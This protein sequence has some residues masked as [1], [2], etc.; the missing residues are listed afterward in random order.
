MEAGN[1]K[2]VIFEI[3]K[4]KYIPP[5]F[6]LTVLKELYSND[7]TLMKIV[8]EKLGMVGYLYEKVKD[9]ENWKPLFLRAVKEVMWDEFLTSSEQ[10]K[11]VSAWRNTEDFETNRHLFRDQYIE[12]DDNWLFRFVDLHSGEMKYRCEK[13]NCSPET[14]EHLTEGDSIVKINFNTT[15]Y[16]KDLEHLFYGF[17]VPNESSHICFKTARAV[18]PDA[19]MPVGSECSLSSNR[20]K[21]DPLLTTL[22][23]V[24][25]T[26]PDG[27]DLGLD[28]DSIKPIRGA[29]SGCFLLDLALRIMDKKGIMNKRNE[30]KRFFYRS[31]ESYKGGHLKLEERKKKSKS[32]KAGEV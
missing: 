20:S 9:D 21:R 27:I 1:D 31:I 22:A 2:K 18:A 15:A 17:L 32:R 24:I 3:E 7:D 4:G 26:L 28:E 25:E 5:R 19:T 14:I 8:K 10:F 6:I 12:K 29:F 11:L 13:D 23:S 16:S 30:V